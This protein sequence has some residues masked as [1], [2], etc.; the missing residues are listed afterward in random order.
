LQSLFY[1][2]CSSSETGA[3]HIY[4]KI[5]TRVRLPSIFSPSWLFRM[6]LTHM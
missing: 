2:P 1:N 3:F 6:Q 5:L 4:E